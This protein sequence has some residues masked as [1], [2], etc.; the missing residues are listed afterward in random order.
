MRA[1]GVSVVCDYPA[2][3]AYAAG[4]VTLA[5]LRT[6]GV[7]DQARLRSAFSGLRTTTLFG[8]FAIDPVSGRQVGHKMLLVQWHRGRKVLI[9]AEPDPNDGAIEFPSGWR[10]VLAS[11]RYFRLSRRDRT[12]ASHYR[13]GSK[14]RDDP[15]EVDD[16]EKD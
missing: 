1:L 6:T 8:D 13:E 7:L 11:M 15:D 10:L 2:A 16:A 9:D 3:Q 4:L 12:R 5:A 14:Y